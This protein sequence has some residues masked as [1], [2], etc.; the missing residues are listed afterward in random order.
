LRPHRQ[1]AGS[2]PR[3]DAP[4]YGQE[5][6][7]VLRWQPQVRRTRSTALRAGLAMALPQARPGSRQRCV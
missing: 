2:K 5:P 1:P 3:R 6:D 7:S 4:A